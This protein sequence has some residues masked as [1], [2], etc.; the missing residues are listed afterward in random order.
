MVSLYL[1]DLIQRTV[2]TRQSLSTLSLM[3]LKI[4][5][6]KAVIPAAVPK[7]EPTHQIPWNSIWCIRGM[8][9]NILQN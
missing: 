6:R 1:H 4:R 7:I 5:N 9:G 3:E 8:S 2:L